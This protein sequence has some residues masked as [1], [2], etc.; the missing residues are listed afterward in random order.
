METAKKK[1]LDSET[2]HNIEIVELKHYQKLYRE[3]DEPIRSAFDVNN[4]RIL[5]NTHFGWEI[6]KELFKLILTFEYHYS[7]KG[8]II[9]IFG[10][11]TESIFHITN[12][13]KLILINGDNFN[14]P[15]ELMNDL[16]ANS[17]GNSRGIIYL[18]NKTNYLNSV[19][20]PFLGID[21]SSPIIKEEAQNRAS[22]KKKTS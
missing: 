16:Y 13:S 22:L 5:I 15:K 6:D 1:I 18:T 17:L 10:F 2:I 7:E 9:Q 20:I 19:L 8:E 3:L 21:Q 12:M 14:M 4:V 11:Q